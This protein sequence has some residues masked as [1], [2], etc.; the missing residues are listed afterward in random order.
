M[1]I[2]ILSIWMRLSQ[3][4]TDNNDNDDGGANDVEG[5]A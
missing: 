1:W 4:S 3:A 5:G 2:V